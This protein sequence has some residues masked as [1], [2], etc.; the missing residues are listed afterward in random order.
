VSPR[1]AFSRLKVP[2]TRNAISRIV[3]WI[4]VFAP[5]GASARAFSAVGVTPS[6]KRVRRVTTDSS[7]VTGCLVLTVCALV[8][9]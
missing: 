8:H 9:H 5:G 3:R 7:T 1:P 6:W 2:H 4:L